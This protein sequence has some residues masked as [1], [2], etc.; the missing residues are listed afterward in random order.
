MPRW[1]RSSQPTTF[2]HWASRA[3]SPAPTGSSKSLMGTPS[4][5][6]LAA[7]MLSMS[8]QLGAVACTACYAT[9][10]H[11]CGLDSSSV[12]SSPLWVRPCMIGK[13]MTPLRS[14]AKRHPSQHEYFRI[15]QVFVRS[16]ISS[17]YA[18]VGTGFWALACHGATVRGGA[19]LHLGGLLVGCSFLFLSAFCHTRSQ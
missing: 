18:A 16:H 7:C 11:A 2:L 3:S 6:R 5:C 15:L 8:G 13:V 14:R 4:S 9:S 1:W 10:M 12:P 17:P 19:D